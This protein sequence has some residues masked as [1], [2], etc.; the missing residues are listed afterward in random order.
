M[1][2]KKKNKKLTRDTVT[3][4]LVQIS[5]N[6]MLESIISLHILLKIPHCI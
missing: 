3:I 1:L 4:D 2:L 5:Q 6:F